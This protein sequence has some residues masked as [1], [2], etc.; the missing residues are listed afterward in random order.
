MILPTIGHSKTMARKW[1]QVTISAQAELLGWIHHSPAELHTFTSS[2]RGGQT[3]ETLPRRQSPLVF[4]ASFQPEPGQL[5][6]PACE[7]S[8]GTRDRISL[9]SQQRAQVNASWCKPSAWL[10]FCQQRPLIY[11]LYETSRCRAL[12]RP[13]SPAGARWFLGCKGYPHSHLWG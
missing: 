1:L 3:A 10:C 12:N 9:P 11:L 5:T 8:L 7:F 2:H 6:H 13:V 4:Y